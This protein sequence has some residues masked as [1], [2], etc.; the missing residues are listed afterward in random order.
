MVQIS[1]GFLGRL[2][3]YPSVFLLGGFKYSAYFYF[4]IYISTTHKLKRS[5]R[6][7][8]LAQWLHVIDAQTC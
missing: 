5:K 2:L 8:S 6:N 3:F 1:T 4:V 7:I